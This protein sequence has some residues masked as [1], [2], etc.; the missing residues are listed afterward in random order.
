MTTLDD[1]NRSRPQ[2]QA[3]AGPPD[4]GFAVGIAISLAG[5][6]IVSWLA[7]VGLHHGFGVSVPFMA[8]FTVMVAFLF[9]VRVTVLVAASGWFGVRM[10]AEPKITAS[11]VVATY[12]AQHAMGHPSMRDALDKLSQ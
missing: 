8:G 6:A 12:A 3:P 9:F 10:T 11:Q 7:G 4:T 2:A 1:L 5:S